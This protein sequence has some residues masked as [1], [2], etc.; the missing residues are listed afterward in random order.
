LRRN[1]GERLVRPGRVASSGRDLQIVT[2]R[3]HLL[4]CS[5]RCRTLILTGERRQ[6]IAVHAEKGLRDGRVLAPGGILT[7]GIDVSHVPVDDDAR[8][9]AADLSAEQQPAV[10]QVRAEMRLPTA[11]ERV[12]AHQHARLAADKT[13]AKL[14]GDEISEGHAFD[15]HVVERREFPGVTTRSKFA[16]L[17]ADVVMNGEFRVLSGERTAYWSDGTVVIRN[18]GAADGGTAFRPANGYDYFLGLH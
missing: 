5:Y 16:D 2:F 3:I 14:I 11:A 7:M 12:E 15:K 17:I 8:R 6:V 1:N 9:P 18:P 4:T 10:P 13:Y